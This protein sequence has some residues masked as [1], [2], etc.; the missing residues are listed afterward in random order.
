MS[1]EAESHGVAPKPK[2]E[3]NDPSP[4]IAT[5]HTRFGK[6]RFKGLFDLNTLYNHMIHWAHEREYEFFETAYKHKWRGKT[7]EVE[8]KWRME[9]EI[10]TFAKGLIKVHFHLWNF[11][12]VE[13]VKNGQKRRMNEARMFIDFTGE[14]QL[15][16]QQ[17][18]NDTWWKRKMRDFYINY[19][20]R[21]EI[22]SHWW[23]KLWY[24]ANKLQQETKRTLGMES[25]SEI[26]D[27][28]W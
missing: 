27:D 3:P 13:V 1:E 9:Q 20:L 6:V 18:W 17:R 28:M 16:W 14:L 19:V 8:I 7:A 10:N 15:D 4:V 21:Q 12:E 11:R 2:F 26:Y 25:E 23:D 22:E 5:L 24:N